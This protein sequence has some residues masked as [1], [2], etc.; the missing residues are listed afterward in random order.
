MTDSQRFIPVALSIAGS[1]SGGGAGIQAD[2]KAFAYCGVHGATAITA[3]TAQNTVGVQAVHTVPPTFIRAQ[4]ESVHQDMPIAAVKVGMLG[5]AITVRTVATILRDL[6]LT[7]VVVDPVMV[8]ESGASLLDADARRALIE[9]LLP[10]ATVI[11]PNVLEARSLAREAGFDDVDDVEHNIEQL[12]RELLKL[13]PQAVVIT[14]GH[15][16]ALSDTLIT[17]DSTATYEGE[18]LTGYSAHGSGCTHSAALAAFLARGFSIAE[19]AQRAKL[20]ATQAVK[21]G[22]SSLGLGTG[23]VDVFGLASSDRS[24]TV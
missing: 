24:L 1:D 2:I 6:A 5:S 19:S 8:A 18:K 12:G 17:A 4:V 3:L 23:P 7:P 9:E 21:H 13:G 22:L 15:T 14:G 10:L 16:Q 11:T 20:I